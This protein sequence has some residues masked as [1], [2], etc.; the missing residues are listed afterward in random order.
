MCVRERVYVRERVCV[1]ESVYVR[2]RVCVRERGGEKESTYI[3]IIYTPNLGFDIAVLGLE[4]EQ[5]RFKGSSG[6]AK[7]RSKGA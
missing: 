6:G 4:R 1:R 7:G 2:E 5:G 3:Y